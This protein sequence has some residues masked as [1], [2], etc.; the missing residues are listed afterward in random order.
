MESP[1]STHSAPLLKRN[2]FFRQPPAAGRPRRG[3]PRVGG[4]RDPTME[5]LRDRMEEVPGW[6]SG[7]IA[8]SDWVTGTL[9]ALE[10]TPAAPGDEWKAA[11]EAVCRLL[12]ALPL[13]SSVEL[14]KRAVALIGGC[15]AASRDPQL[16]DEACKSAV[17]LAYA[18]R[19][20]AELARAAAAEALRGRPPPDTKPLLAC[21][22]EALKVLCPRDV[23]PSV[24]QE[25]GEDEKVRA[26]AKRAREPSVEGR[27]SAPPPPPPPPPP[28]PPPAEGG[29][30]LAGVPKE[31]F[32]TAARLMD[33]F[34]YDPQRTTAQSISARCRLDVAAVLALFAEG[35]SGVRGAAERMRREDFG[36]FLRALEG[37]AG[38]RPPP[39][40]ETSPF[41]MVKR[42]PRGSTAAQVLKLFSPFSRGPMPPDAVRVIEDRLNKGTMVAF[43]TFNVAEDAI[44]ARAALQGS[45]GAPEIRP[46]VGP[47]GRKIFVSGVPPDGGHRDVGLAF[48]RFGRVE[49]VYV[50]Q[51]RPGAKTNIAFVTFAD[52]RAAENAVT[53]CLDASKGRCAPPAMGD[54]PLTAVYSVHKEAAEPRRRAAEADPRDAH[55]LKRAKTEAKAAGASPRRPRGAWGAARAD[56][57]GPWGD[58]EYAPRPPRADGDRGGAAP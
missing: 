32:A 28:R 4:A 42:L 34:T 17:T 12:I 24:P 37:R 57:D 51:H 54:W 55:G 20:T 46:W 45:A 10:R 58:G 3:A 30:P 29:G 19:E 18:F 48:S 2:T 41:L 44:R 8:A 31:A 56:G 35:R 15:M 23:P 36:A 38:A 27:S 40:L 21:C 13:P 6:H 49:Q 43:I 25:E 9:A 22:A 5:E 11:L 14:A 47:K 1:P 33:G 53:C 16:V 7:K 50:P 52:V 39:F 26:P